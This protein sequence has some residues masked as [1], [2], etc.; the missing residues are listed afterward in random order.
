MHGRWTLPGT[1]TVSVVGN[2]R[3]GRAAGARQNQH[4]LVRGN[5]VREIH[6]VF[7]QDVVHTPMI[8]R[9]FTAANRVVCSD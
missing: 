6:G 5:L 3:T 1:R 2:T 7:S 8:T 9:D 4:A